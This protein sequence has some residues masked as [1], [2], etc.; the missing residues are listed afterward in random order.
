[1]AP[2]SIARRHLTDCRK[3]RP[4]YAGRLLV[5][6]TILPEDVIT[7]ETTLSA[8]RERALRDRGR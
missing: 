2:A 4:A 7:P 3:L 6:I 5:I 8:V 1:M